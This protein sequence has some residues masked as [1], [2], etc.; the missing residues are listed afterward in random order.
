LEI[1]VEL[2]HIR[3]FLAVAEERHFTKA[4]SKVGIGQ[5]PLSQQIKDL[6]GEV[7]AA[8]FRR[9]AH[10]AELTE[11]GK[12]FLAGVK[13]MPLIAQRATMAARRAARG[14]LGSLRVGFTTTA[15]FNV[16]VPSAIRTF[17]HAYPEIHLTLEEANTTR[18]VTGLREGTLDV[19]FL[20]PSAPGTEELQLRRLSD[21]SMVVALP[22][23]HPAAALE[24]IDLA[25][26]KDD[27]FL[28]FPRETAPTIYDTVVD[29]CRKA[30]FEPVISQFAPHFTTI[31]NLV[32][33]ELGVSIVP[34]SM[35]QVRVAGM[36]Y[37]QIAGQAP[38]TGLAL[39]Y[40]R[41]E[42]SP[43]V[44]NFIARAVS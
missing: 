22:E 30:G 9:L 24:E 32:A 20:R 29:A 28:L 35:M 5:P 43:V 15:T 11:A 34:A 10:G 13:E 6:E 14:E 41:G 27:P 4:A 37:R 8:L 2:R 19:V 3:Y 31:V 33:A 17:R 25:M 18:L 26:L 44:R 36:A 40:R 23:R 12:A 38:T 21:E 16:V 39:A 7:G 1:T 42:T